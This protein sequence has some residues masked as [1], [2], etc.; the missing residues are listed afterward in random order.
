MWKLALRENSAIAFA[1]L[2]H[3]HSQLIEL[4]AKALRSLR[5]L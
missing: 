2:A 1:A 3:Q 4:Y 5:M